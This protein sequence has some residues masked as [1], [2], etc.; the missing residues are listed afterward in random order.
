MTPQ[1]IRASINKVAAD[2]D[3]PSDMIGTHEG[4]KTFDLNGKKYY[5]AGIA[6]TASDFDQKKQELIFKTM[7]VVYNKHV[8]PATIDGLV[9]HEIE[10]IKYQTALNRYQDEYKK[11]MA[12]PGAAS[13]HGPDAVMKPDGSLRE[14][15]DKKYPAYTAMHE[16]FF[17]KNGIKEFA[18][19]DGVSEYSYEWW[20]NWKAKA[21]S[22]DYFN[23][24]QSAIHETLAEMA[25]TKYE[26][27]KFPDHMG[28]RILSWRGEDTPKPSKA[29]MDKN[30]K[31]WRDLYRAVDKV[32]KSR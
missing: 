7:V 11:V 15:Y 18:E 23:A 28:E 10:H 3:F 27:G 13:M 14:P 21:G 29:Q 5:A 24:G 30:A 25:R 17:S 32:W 19:A 20:L 4:D 31:L 2:H 26:T 1:E 8:S 12:E 6:Y 16:A 22:G 9:S